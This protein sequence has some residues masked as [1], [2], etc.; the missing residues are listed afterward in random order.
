[1]C[2]IHVKCLVSNVWTITNISLKKNKKNLVINGTQ[3][4][5]EI[6]PFTLGQLKGDTRECSTCLE[7]ISFQSLKQLEP[8]K[9]F[10][11]Q[12]VH[13]EGVQTLVIAWWS[14]DF[15]CDSSGVANNSRVTRVPYMD[16]SKNGGTLNS[17]II[18]GF[19]IINHPFWGTP[20]FG[21]LHIYNHIT[22][23]K[24][25]QGNTLEFMINSYISG[26]GFNYWFPGVPCPHLV[27]EFS[28][29]T[30]VQTDC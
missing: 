6:P 24:L 18:I 26:R 25:D 20:I 11:H 12:H 5:P 28:L 22:H 19:S 14:Y 29:H 27:G 10:S 21:N 15:W 30:L 4:F 13:R 16:V 17:S 8:Q 2:F 9:W 1:M 23:S 7:H 3:R